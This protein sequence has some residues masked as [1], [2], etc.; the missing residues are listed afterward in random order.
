M[1]FKSGFVTVL[2]KPNVGKSS[3]I[4]AIIGEKVSIVSPKP[5]TTRNNILGIY[6][7]ENVQIVFTDTPGLH[8]G[9]TRLDAFMQKSASSAKRGSD[10]IV[11][12]L[13]G[14]KPI[15]K[16]DVAYIKG[17]KDQSE[18]LIVVVNKTDETTFE[19]LYPQLDKLNQLDF[20][21]EI[22]PTSAIKG[23][24]VDVLVNTIIKLLPEGIP[25]FDQDQ[26]TNNS[27]R[28]MVAEII[29]EKALWLLQKEIPHGIG[30]EIVLFEETNKLVNI[31][32]DIIC[33]KQTHKQIIIGA[34]GNTLKDIGTRA[35]VDIEKLLGQKVFLKLFVKVRANWRDKAYYVSD[36]GY[37]ANNE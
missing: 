16:Q 24:N 22:I 5:Q 27:L 10:I 20:V 30:V 4:N 6:N 32:A 18:H 19:K 29:R 26:Y 8:Q 28:F 36:L 31:S 23:N 35:R 17:L 34:K 9:G 33:E 7:T 1:T 15:G 25:Y 12:V 2:G 13:D 21:N 37:K 14:T 3:L 11:Y